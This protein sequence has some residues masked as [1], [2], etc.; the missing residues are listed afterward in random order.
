MK[1]WSQRGQWL[2]GCLGVGGSFY[3]LVHFA[4]HFVWT[5]PPIGL[6]FL[7]LVCMVIEM[8]CRA[9]RLVSICGVVG[10]TISLWEA[11]RMNAIGD[12]FAAVTPARLG[13]DVSRLAIFLRRKIKLGTATLILVAESFV[14][15]ISLLVLVGVAAIYTVWHP[16]AVFSRASFVHSLLLFA[17]LIGALLAV[18][19]GLM[20]QQKTTVRW[21]QW[22]RRFDLLGLTMIHHLIRLG[23]LPLIIYFVSPE[24]SRFVAWI[25]SFILIYGFNFLPIPS[26]GG[27]IELT[28]MTVLAPTLGDAASVALVWWRIAGHYIYILWGALMI[29]WSRQNRGGRNR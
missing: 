3:S 11:M 1:K 20:R 16:A 18:F 2:F 12:F 28:F 8:A 21:R 29:G 22:F 5:W 27:T 10:E 17:G 24:T 6:I 19:I 9:K 7:L 25:W 15:Y 14:D 4:R 23:F 13:G 26:G